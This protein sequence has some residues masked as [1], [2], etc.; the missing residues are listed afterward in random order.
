MTEN[1]AAT[2]LYWLSALAAAAY[3]TAL[4]TRS[5]SALKSAV[6]TIPVAALALAGAVSG[7]PAPIVLGLAL[8]AGGDF[9]LSRPGER[10]FLYGMAA[11][12]AGHLAY[13]V[14][15]LDPTR[16][17][18]AMIPGLILLALAASTELWLAPRTGALRGPVR[19]YV[20]VISAMALAAFTLPPARG[21][22][23]AGTLLFLASDLLLAL[24][25]FVLGSGRVKGVLS[26]ALWAAYWSGQALILLG[27][28]A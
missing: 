4:C 2:I 8:G 16:I 6:K 5:A 28:A 25:R 24:E 13:G 14:A 10:A 3:G 19:A 23:L 26:R 18:E 11:F 21:A 9:F 22:A 1:A 7:A 27:M 20:I 12:G 15:F 17:G